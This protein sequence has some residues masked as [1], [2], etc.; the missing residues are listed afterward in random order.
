M[1]VPWRAPVMP[2]M[3]SA[4]VEMLLCS[5]GF[6]FGPRGERRERL[7]QGGEWCKVLVIG[8]LEPK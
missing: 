5:V 8:G 3:T 2:P 7:S 1:A 6:V 4:M